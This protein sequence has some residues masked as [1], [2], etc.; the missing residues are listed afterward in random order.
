MAFILYILYLASDSSLR[1][2]TR[3]MSGK[4]ES[5]RVIFSSTGPIKF[6]Q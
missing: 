5:S 4:R 1:G 6:E 3:E 2:A